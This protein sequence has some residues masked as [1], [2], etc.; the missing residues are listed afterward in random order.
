MLYL[1]ITGKAPRR[2]CK[3]VVQWFKD[4]YMPFHHLDITVVHRGLKRE[5]AMGFCTVMDCDHRPREFLIEMETTLKE[6]QYVTV[7][8]HELWHVWQHVNGSLRDKR[9]VRHWKNVDADHLSYEDQ[10]WEHE[11]EKMEKVLYNDYVGVKT[12]SNRLTNS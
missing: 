8:L 9:G 5:H 11:A 2:R 3:K 12:F 6:E 10:P 7:L 4:K 1:D